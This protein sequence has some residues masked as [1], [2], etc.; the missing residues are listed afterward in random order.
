MGLPVT[1]VYLLTVI[2]IAPA[3]TKIGVYPLAAHLFALHF[4]SISNVTPPFALAAYAA[5][6]IAD[7]DP[8]KTGLTA[9]RITIVAFIVPF[10]FVYNP[11]IILHGT[12]LQIIIGV[13]TAIIG[14]SA[15]AISVSG[16]LHAKISIFNRLVLAIS[17]VLLFIR[18]GITDIVGLLL[19]T[20]SIFF[21]YY[22]EKN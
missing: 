21:H 16:Y 8:V 7:S 2:L 20:F 9:F 4:A 17:S 14:C 5:A 22:Y 6:A 11:S 1:V 3:L 13:C 10:F 12:F 18:G 19:L 15:L